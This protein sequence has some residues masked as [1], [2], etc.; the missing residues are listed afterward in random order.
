LLFAAITPGWA[1]ASMSVQG[2]K[3][4]Q[5]TFIR[6]HPLSSLILTANLLTLNPQCQ[7]GHDQDTRPRSPAKQGC[8]SRACT[9]MLSNMPPARRVEPNAR[10]VAASRGTT[11]APGTRAT[12]RHTHEVPTPRIALSDR[13][14]LKRT[15]SRPSLDLTP[16]E[17]G[18]G[19]F[20]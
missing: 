14:I 12:A 4:R 11:P 16:F 2:G 10:A 3:A 15:K 18:I 5:R 19:A 13:A 9:L 17:Y 7:S 6:P 1:L 20:F 8:S